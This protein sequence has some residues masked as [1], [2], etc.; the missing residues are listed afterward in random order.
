MVS[1][2]SDQEQLVSVAGGMLALS[3][4]NLKAV[5]S[6]RRLVMGSA[7]LEKLTES[8]AAYE[9]GL[10]IGWELRIPIEDGRKLVLVGKRKAGRL[11]S[12]PL[13]FCSQFVPGRGAFECLRMRSGETREHCSAD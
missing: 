10:E 12:S 7:S 3:S 6:P 13:R 8:G 9:C 5:T 4:L 11:T 1:M 2:W